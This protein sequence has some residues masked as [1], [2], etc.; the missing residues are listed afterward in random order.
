MPV[1]LNLY[2]RQGNLTLAIP[3]L[4]YRV[5]SYSTG[6]MGGPLRARVELRG[7][8]AELLNATNLIRYVAEIEDDVEGVVWWGYVAAA[9]VRLG[10][11]ELGR[12]VRGMGNR[13]AV[14]YA[15]TVPDPST[16]SRKA[17]TPWADDEL[18]Q[19]E[20]GAKELLV[21]VG[22]FDEDG[23]TFQ[24]DLILAA[25]KDP[26]E[27][28]DIT[29]ERGRALGGELD[30]EG[31]W[32]TLDWRRYAQP[33]GLVR[34]ATSGGA[35]QDITTN[36]ASPRTSAVAQ[37]FQLPV[38]S[39]T[40]WAAYEVHLRLRTTGAPTD[41][42]T[43][44]LRADGGGVPGAVL[45][46]V[47]VAASALANAASWARFVLASPVAL[48]LATTYWIVAERNEPTGTSTI[49]VDVAEGGG[50]YGPGVLRLWD[51]TTW[52]ARS[53]DADMMFQVVGREET[54]A[55]IAAAVAASGQFF[56]GTDIIDAS[57]RVVEQ[58]RS[59]ERSALQEIV[60][61]L[62]RGTAAGRRLLA[63]VTQDRRLQVSAEPDPPD[64]SAASHYISRSGQVM[65]RLAVPI[66]N[67]ACVSG[68][69][70]RSEALAD[71]IYADRANFLE[72]TE[73]DAA[74]DMLRFTTKGQRS[75]WDVT[76][77]RNE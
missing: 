55:Q 20:Y 38:T 54:T 6:A 70:V 5:R 26:I 51:G 12:E 43:V 11:V 22:D 28:I 16:G 13:V 9:R 56:T 1:R 37:S 52:A 41:N 64:V 73:Y 29:G 33:A 67:A 34:F 40:G 76:K 23:A 3:D 32:Y 27:T 77:I 50:T 74:S 47:A 14:A 35:R 8:E 65:T 46:S 61:L 42:L 59:G 66:P 7:N 31:W 48:S 68:I 4:G 71:T 36:A 69:W 72:V 58:Y 39:P 53:P 49:Q 24:R 63:R 21:S 30:L 57:G 15:R 18:S 45:S 44:S 17:I 62:D 19:A 2:S 60:G 75:P 25:A 10:N